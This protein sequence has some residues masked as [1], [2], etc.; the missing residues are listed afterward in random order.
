[1]GHIALSPIST[2]ALDYTYLP[3]SQAYFIFQDRSHFLSRVS[4]MLMTAQTKPSFRPMPP[5]QSQF[6]LPS[7]RTIAMQPFP[8]QANGFPNLRCLFAKSDLNL[9]AVTAN[10]GRNCPDHLDSVLP[11]ISQLTRLSDQRTIDLQEG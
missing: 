7:A 11:W 8:L 4:M 6:L 2:V 10:S 3:Y 5:P 1:M 9:L